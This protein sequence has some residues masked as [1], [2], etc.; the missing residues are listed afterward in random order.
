[1]IFINYRREDSSSTAGRLYDRLTY[2][3]GRKNIFMDVDHIP[4]GVDF[5]AHLNSQLAA[6]TTLLVVIGPRWLDAKDEVGQRRLDQP[7]DFVAIEIAAALDRDIRVIPVLVDGAGL[8]KARELPDKLKRLARRQAFEVRQNQ[9]GRDADTLVERIRG[10]LDASLAIRARR[11]LVR[12]ITAAA[13]LLIGWFGFSWISESGPVGNVP[14][15]VDAMIRHLLNR[16]ET[17]TP[18]EVKTEARRLADVKAEQERQAKAAVD[19]EARRKAEEAER[20]RWVAELERQAKAMADEEARR[21]EAE[22]AKAE[23]ERQANAMID[24][25]AQRRAAEVE[26]QI[27]ADVKTQK[28]AAPEEIT[29]RYSP[30]SGVKIANLSRAL[31]DELQLQNVERG[32]AIVDVGIGSVA[33]K[34][35]FRRGDVIDEFNGNSIAK[36][37][38]VEQ[39]S[40][41]ISLAWRITVLRS[42]Q[43]IPFEFRQFSP[44]EIHRTTPMRPRPR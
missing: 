41:V 1:M 30:L 26:R 5:V 12:A 13:L 2:A 31:V 32:V 29:I 7:D 8:P 44:W 39:L 16:I 21:K 11:G 42:G 4:P 18:Q 27:L 34:M 40:I 22:A 14:F 19:E 38:D 6:C 10:A 36:A 33:D 37:H 23:Q 3:F 15:T 9:F 24:E 28:E 20:Q 43:R 25:E 17:V 35:G